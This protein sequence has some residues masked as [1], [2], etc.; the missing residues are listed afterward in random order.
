MRSEKPVPHIQPPTAN[1]ALTDPE[2][3]WYIRMPDGSQYGPATGAVLEY[4]IR[5]RRID[6]TA[7]IWRDGWPQWSP[8]SV[9]FPELAEVFSEK[10]TVSDR[11]AG[12][13]LKKSR[14]DR[15]KRTA[16][17]IKLIVVLSGAILVL[18]SFLVWL[19]NR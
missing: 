14:L 11:S 6:P 16:R 4:W 2:A 18:G 8:A 7:L 5:E 13:L 19:L 10:V 1:A 17:N 3:V 12:Y 15:K 9:V